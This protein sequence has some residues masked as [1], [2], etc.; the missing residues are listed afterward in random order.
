VQKIATAWEDM[1]YDTT[2]DAAHGGWN[3]AAPE[4][5]QDWSSISAKEFYKRNPHD[6]NLSSATL[7]PNTD[8]DDG[9]G[10]VQEMIEVNGGMDALTGINSRASSSTIEDSRF[11]DTS[12]MRSLEPI[13]DSDAMDVDGHGRA[14]YVHSDAAMPDAGEPRVQHIEIAEKKGV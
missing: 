14:S 2:G 5:E 12:D 6:S 7:T 9:G 3:Q 4:Y 1:E 8:H 11:P 10:G 13:P